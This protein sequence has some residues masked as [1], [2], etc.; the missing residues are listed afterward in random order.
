LAADSSLGSSLGSIPENDTTLIGDDWICNEEDIADKSGISI[1]KT[2]R[3][4]RSKSADSLHK[5]AQ[6]QRHKRLGRRTQSNPALRERVPKAVSKV[7]PTGK[8]QDDPICQE[9]VTNL[10]QSCLQAHSKYTKS[11]TAVRRNSV[12]E[13]SVPWT[14]SEK[15]IDGGMPRSKSDALLV[16]FG[17][18]KSW[19]PPKTDNPLL[20]CLMGLDRP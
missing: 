20:T 9:S 18:S 8:K 17:K 16:N 11:G 14:E 19:E 3:A 6:A 5:G 4:T 15:K 13:G 2:S 1:S 10:I 7:S 12:P